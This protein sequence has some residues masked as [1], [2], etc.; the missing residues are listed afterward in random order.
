MSRNGCIAKR[1]VEFLPIQSLFSVFYKTRALISVTAEGNFTTIHFDKFESDV[2]KTCALNLSVRPR[3]VQS[4]CFCR[5]YRS[6]CCIFR[7]S[8]DLRIPSIPTQHLRTGAANLQKKYDLE[9]DV[10]DDIIQFRQPTQQ[11]HCCN[12]LEKGNDR[13][14]FPTLTWCS[15]LH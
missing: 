2:K 15:G 10:V 6:S 9:E 5:R 11:G 3:D 7:Y 1:F 13:Q 12:L 4:S 14:R 8:A